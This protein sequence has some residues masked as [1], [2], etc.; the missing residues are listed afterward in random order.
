MEMEYVVFGSNGTLGVK[1]SNV[2]SLEK[3][4]RREWL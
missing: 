2:L 1:V 3:D 4:S